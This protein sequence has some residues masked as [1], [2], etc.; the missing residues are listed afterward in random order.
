MWY[1]YAME[2]YSAIKKNEIM[3][4]AAMWID[5]EMI[6]LSE[7]SWKGKDKGRMIA[8][9]LPRFFQEP[10][11]ASS[12]SPGGISRVWLFPSLLSHSLLADHLRCFSFGV[13]LNNACYKYSCTRFL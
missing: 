7:V 4:F 2:Y 11:V 1:I 10:T 12:F 5:L 9:C 13:I 8:C 3:P 6:I